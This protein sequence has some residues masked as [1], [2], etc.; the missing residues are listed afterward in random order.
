MSCKCINVVIKDVISIISFW[1]GNWMGGVLIGI[2]PRASKSLETA[3]GGVHEWAADGG[4]DILMD[5][6]RHD[7]R[8]VDGSGRHDFWAAQTRGTRGD[9]QHINIVG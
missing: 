8:V 5:G 2:S 4:V 6:G 1:C 7:F 3:L 9:L